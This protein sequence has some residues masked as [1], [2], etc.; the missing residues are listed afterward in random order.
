MR[1]NHYMNQSN[2][3]TNIPLLGSIQKAGK[4]LTIALICLVPF[5]IH[6]KYFPLSHMKT[7]AFLKSG[8]THVILYSF[9]SVWLIKFKFYFGW[10]FCQIPVHLSGVTY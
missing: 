8:A 1:Y 5:I 6:M 9:W 10:K 4:D 7:S 3:F 2:Q